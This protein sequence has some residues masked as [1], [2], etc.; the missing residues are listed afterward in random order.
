MSGRAKYDRDVN[1]LCSFSSWDVDSKEAILTLHNAQGE[2]NSCEESRSK[3]S[4]QLTSSEKSS[5]TRL[6]ELLQVLPLAD[7]SSQAGRFTRR[8]QLELQ[9]QNNLPKIEEG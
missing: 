5:D 6:N 1:S 3:T 4:S 8:I 7:C 2:V 9:Y